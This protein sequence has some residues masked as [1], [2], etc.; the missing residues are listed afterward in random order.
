MA[1]LNYSGWI[2]G[3]EQKQIKQNICIF[4]LFV[5]YIVTDQWTA[6]LKGK[7]ELTEREPLFA[8]AED[9]S[10]QPATTTTRQHL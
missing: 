2:S 1:K 9:A 7:R 6:L 10:L 8:Q 5:N 3:C 4:C